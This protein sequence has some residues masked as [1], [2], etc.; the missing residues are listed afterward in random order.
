M[1]AKETEGAQFAQL[2]AYGAG[3]ARRAVVH[4][5]VHEQRRVRAHVHAAALACV[6]TARV[7]NY[8]KQIFNDNKNF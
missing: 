2:R 8:I 7:L 1:R 4:D 6:A 3:D 5:L